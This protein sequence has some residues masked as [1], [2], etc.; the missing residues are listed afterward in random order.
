MTTPGFI[1]LRSDTH[2]FKKEKKNN[3]DRKLQALP[4]K[5]C[6]LLVPPTNSEICYLLVSRWKT[7][8]SMG[9]REYKVE[10]RIYFHQIA[11]HKHMQKKNYLKKKIQIISSMM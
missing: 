8:N 1:S 4:F 2:T 3:K 11:D 10:K 5:V 7:T 9:A 6:S